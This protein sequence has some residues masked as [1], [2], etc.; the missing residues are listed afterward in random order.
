MEEV[1]ELREQLTK[2]NKVSKAKSKVDRDFSN[3]RETIKNLKAEKSFLKT[4]KTK[5]EGETKKLE[6]RI[7]NISCAKNT[8]SDRDIKNDN[9]DEGK[10]GDINANNITSTSSSAFV[11]A[12]PNS[13]PSMVSY[14]NP[15][16][17]T[18]PQGAHSIPSM[19]NHCTLSLLPPGPPPP[20]DKEKL[21][22]KEEFLQLWAE[23]REQVRK[24]WA[25]ILLKVNNLN[26]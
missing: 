3:A 9:D 20:P 18:I 12:Y 2:L 21:V 6:K 10:T 19:I 11:P 23:H 8:F 25:E 16:L 1:Q 22:S 5:L 24:D 17:E 13:F 4:H 14:W 7:R 15:A 26:I